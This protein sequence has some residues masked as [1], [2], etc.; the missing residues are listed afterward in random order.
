MHHLVVVMPRAAAPTLNLSISGAASADACLR[1]VLH[2]ALAGCR[3]FPRPPQPTSARQ[4]A[5]AAGY[6]QRVNTWYDYRAVWSAHPW[7]L[8]LAI[9]AAAMMAVGVVGT[10]AGGALA[11]FFVPGLAGIFVHHFVVARKM[12]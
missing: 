9:A 2:C 8:G 1:H 11:I 3:R 4:T 6:G 5:A 12:S 7:V 10:L